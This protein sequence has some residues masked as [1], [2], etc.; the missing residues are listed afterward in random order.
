MCN[1]C[2]PKRFWTPNNVVKYDSKTNP[3]IWLE[4]YRLPCMVGGADG[5]LFI[6]QF[7]PIYL[8][9]T[10]MAWLDHMPGNLIDC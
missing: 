9:D 3:S 1:T 8:V 5:D 2:F 4:D 7:L 6:I 10:T